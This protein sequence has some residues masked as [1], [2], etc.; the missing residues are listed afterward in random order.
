MKKIKSYIIN[1][2]VV[3]LQASKDIFSK[4]AIIALKR[5]VNLTTGFQYPFQYPITLGSIKFHGYF[6]E[7]KIS[8]DA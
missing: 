8:S 7:N 3:P 6:E 5:S 1:S 2:K 4:I